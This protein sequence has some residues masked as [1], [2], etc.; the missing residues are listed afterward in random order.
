L[1][2]K[3]GNSRARED[4]PLYTRGFHFL[5]LY[6]RIRERTRLTR[7]KG[8]FPESREPRAGVKNLVIASIFLAALSG[9]AGGG[10][11]PAGPHSMD[12]Q[13]LQR[14]VSAAS[15]RSG[16]P[17]ALISS[18]IAAESGGDPSAV[19]RTGAAGLMQLMPATALQYGVA[20]RFDPF[21][22]VEGGSRYL[23]DLLVRYRHNVSLALAAYNAGPGAVDAS[24]GIPPFPET[25]AY[26]ARVTAALRN[27]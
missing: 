24:K 20:N 13:S 2:V 26:V 8:R 7:H 15:I 12:A 14:L 17:T 9:C 23:H 18:V 3:R 19:S 5:P 25:R 22:N 6:D 21:E 1:P 27:N 16:V 10:F 11:I 4:L